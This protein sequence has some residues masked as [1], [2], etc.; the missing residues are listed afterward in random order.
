MLIFLPI[1]FFYTY[2]VF[3]RYTNPVEHRMLLVM[4]NKE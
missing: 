2:I 1:H 4:S 3:F